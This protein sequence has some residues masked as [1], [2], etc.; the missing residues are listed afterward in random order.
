MMRPDLDAAGVLAALPRRIHE[1]IL[2]QAALA[3]ALL[4]DA[5]AWSFGDLAEAIRAG[6]AWL[7]AAGVRGG[8]RVLLITENCREAAALLF[9]CS[10]LDAW[11]VLVNARLSATEIEVLDKRCSP[12][13]I[14]AVLGSVQG[15]RHAAHF[16]LTASEIRWLR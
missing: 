16:G 2:A 10:A 3:P 15:R 11:A 14:C 4:D 5:G 6:A 12:R 9:A 1:P 13:L 8:D 7:Q